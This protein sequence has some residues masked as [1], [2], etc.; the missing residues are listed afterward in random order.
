MEVVQA[1]RCS[2]SLRAPCGFSGG[3]D[4]RYSP[5]T[6]SPSAIVQARLV[7]KGSLAQWLAA[8]GSCSDLGWTHSGPTTSLSRGRHPEQNFSQYL[9]GYAG[10]QVHGD[11]GVDAAGEVVV[12]GSVVVV[13]VVIVDV[14]AE[15]VL[16]GSEVALEVASCGVEME[17]SAVQRLLK[18]VAQCLG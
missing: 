13:V 5:Q 2:S 15:V 9:R 12:V 7:H 16:R 14:A 8:Q 4:G 11:V 10:P 1:Q 18:R 6:A 3:G 17:G